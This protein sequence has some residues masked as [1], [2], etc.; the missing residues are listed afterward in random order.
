MEIK[1]RG[2]NI[3]KAIKDLK[4]KLS[5]EGV[6]K[7]LKK[8]RFY[9]KPSVKEKRKRIEARKARMKASRFKRHA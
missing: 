1:V 4:I 8:R 9:E 7:E 6:F 3:E 2:S 5:K